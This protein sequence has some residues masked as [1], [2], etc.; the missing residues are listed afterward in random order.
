MGILFHHILYPNSL[1]SD[2][3]SV[4]LGT[5]LHYYDI[6]TQYIATQSDHHKLVHP[7]QHMIMEPR[8]YRIITSNIAIWSMIRPTMTLNSSN[9]LTYTYGLITTL[10]PTNYSRATMNVIYHFYIGILPQSAHTT[11]QRY[12]SSFVTQQQR[13]H[14]QQF[15]RS[16][17]TPHI[18]S[19]YWDNA[20]TQPDLLMVLN[21]I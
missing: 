17:A 19:I 14:E 6:H 11:I 1:G 16:W 12:F 13:A 7:Y 5:I 15:P 3:F 9:V 20:T 8:N 10:S 2:I 4:F 18:M 21:F